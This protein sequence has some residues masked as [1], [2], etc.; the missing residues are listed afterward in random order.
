[1]ASP[2]T[3][4]EKK[5]VILDFGAVRTIIQAWRTFRKACKMAPKRMWFQQGLF[6]APHAGNGLA[7]GQ[8]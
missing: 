6:T 7:P 4:E 2:F 5:W 8:V 3:E 1:M